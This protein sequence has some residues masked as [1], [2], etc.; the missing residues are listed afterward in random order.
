MKNKLLIYAVGGMG[1]RFN[2]IINGLYFNEEYFNGDVILYWPNEETCDC[3]F[4]DLFELPSNITA[5]NTLDNL[6][7]NMFKIYGKYSDTRPEVAPVV[8]SYGSLI[9][10][11]DN[12]NEY[13]DNVATVTDTPYRD[14]TEEHR[15]DILKMF[16][17]TKYIREEV[18]KFCKDNN[19]N[20][21]TVGLHIRRTDGEFLLGR[22]DD[23][24]INQIRNNKETNTFICSDSYET[25][26]KLKSLFPDKVCFR[27]KSSYT[28]KIYDG[29][30]NNIRVFD[31]EKNKEINIKYNVKISKQAVIDGLIDILILSKTNFNNSKST[32]CQTAWYLR[33][34]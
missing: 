13:P 22:P 6:D 23:Y 15:S 5:I 1:N 26:S 29:Q 31:K 10:N 21:D 34:R 9:D 20:V 19:I 24:F 14:I 28:E 11:P 8:G 16:T 32:F 30:W 18:N 27:K 7:M 33:D 12:L 3:K 2:S 17:P 25:E 4:T